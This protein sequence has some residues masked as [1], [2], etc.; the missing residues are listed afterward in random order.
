MKSWLSDFF[1]NFFSQAVQVQNYELKNRASYLIYN[2]N[3]FLVSIQN[4]KFIVIQTSDTEKNTLLQYQKQAQIISESEG[5]NVVFAFSKM[6]SVQ[7]K[8]FIKQHIPFISES[9]QVY[10][11][12]I[13]LLLRGTVASKT[14]IS[15]DKMMAAT[16]KIFLHILYSHDEEFKCPELAEKLKIS[17]M[18]VTRGC[19]QLKAMELIETETRV[20][21]NYIHPVCR[22]KDLYEKSK[23]FLINPVQ[24]IILIKR[25]ELPEN[26]LIA[27]ESLLSEETMLGAPKVPFYAVYKAD[28]K[29]KNLH[30]QE[31]R[32]SNTEGMVYLQLWK[33]EPEL[34]LQ[35]GF[36]DPVSLA[37]SLSDLYDERVEGE[38][39]DLLGEFKW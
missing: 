7:Q 22:G 31:V 26:A 36:I 18:S 15:S 39:E 20:R 34:F 9:G 35:N 37:C 14:Q 32:W 12:F 8:A 11:P 29:G 24:E 19:E 23:Q 13:G 30:P 4:Q 27:G 38:L 17:N 16:Q 33:Y 1:S 3:F 6:T 28:V 10:I 25:E 5:V 21:T 2:R